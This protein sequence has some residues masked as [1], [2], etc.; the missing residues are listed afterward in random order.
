[1]KIEVLLLLSIAIQLASLTNAD[2]SVTQLN[3]FKLINITIR[4]L[5]N[6]RV[7]IK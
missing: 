2:V 3:I 1:M 5:K 4:L 6:V 7:T